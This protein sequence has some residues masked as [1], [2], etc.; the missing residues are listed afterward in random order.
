MTKTIL[1]LLG[2]VLLS[3]SSYATV[4]KTIFKERGLEGVRFDVKVD[5]VQ[6]GAS[7][8]TTHA[9][10][11][12]Q[13]RLKGVDAYSGI[14][15]RPG[16]PK[17]PV[18]RF[19]VQGD[20]TV[21]VG[22][23][24]VYQR[25]LPTGTRIEPSLESVVKLPHASAKLVLNPIA[26][27][28]DDLQPSQLYSIAA[29]GSQN[30]QQLKLVT[31]YPITYKAKSGKWTFTQNFTVVAKRQPVVQRRGNPLFAFVVGAKF[32]A[33][34]SLETY[35]Q[36]KQKQGYN[37]VMG[38]MG[39]DFKDQDSIR[40]WLKGQLVNGL[41]YAMIVGDVED[42]PSHDSQIISGVTDHYYRAIDTNDYNSDINGADIGLGRVSVA[43][44]QQ[45][46]VVV[47]KFI[48]Y[49]Q[50]AVARPHAGDWAK[51]VSF[52]ATDDRY[53]I[54]EGTHNYVIDTYT[55]KLGYSGTF[56]S[57]LAPQGGDRLYA[58]THHAGTNDLL[59][60]FSEGR[61]IIDYSGHGGDTYWVGPQFTQANIQ[62]IANDD[63]LPFVVGNACNTG[64]FTTSE[65]FGETWIRSNKAIAYWGS[66]DSTYWDEDDILERKMADG[67][68][69][70]GRLK[71]GDFTNY[72]M[73]AL[74][75]QYGGQ[76]KSAYYWETYVLFGDPSID[77]RLK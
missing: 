38:V 39:K 57:I 76:G 70:Y 12:Q 19:L 3:T 16:F 13:F 49:Q 10:P 66:M 64:E 73:T 41:K 37:V 34:P 11:L 68:F 8:F 31:L 1:L 54:A 74:W 26:Y 40:A 2:T 63:A 4:T 35:A 23:E 53:E 46:K 30:G 17:L 69:Q 22:K 45:L 28:S 51:H 58:I 36:F 59:K 18:V 14:I 52:V 50:A 47:D 67:I 6:T 43:N 5:G 75:A 72:A 56:P 44:E 9:A 7:R 25:A 77:L 62:Q 24:G 20:V 60:A 71:L 55:K 15:Y 65:A 48:R 27:E 61:S 21:T 33:S 29:A 42:V 32:A